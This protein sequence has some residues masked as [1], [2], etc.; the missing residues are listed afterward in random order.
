MMKDCCHVKYQILGGSRR[1]REERVQIGEAFVES[2]IFLEKEKE[3]YSKSLM[4]I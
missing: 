4:C 1:Y 2:L 3:K